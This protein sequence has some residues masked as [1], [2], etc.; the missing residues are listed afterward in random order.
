MND[1]YIR[2]DVERVRAKVNDLLLNF[3]ELAADPDLLVDTLEG[4]SDYHKVLE[5]LLACIL[6]LESLQTAIVD[7]VKSLQKRGEH[8]GTAADKLRDMARELL[9]ESGLKSV[10]LPEATLSLRQT[11]P[12]VQVL[13][14]TLIPDYY[15]RVKR[16]VNKILIRS[17]L[18]S[19]D[20]I[21]GA[22][23]GNPSIVLAIKV[24]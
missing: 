5:R 21:P 3:P 17:H 4:E 19:G 10:K 16:E 12:K 14:E 11:P 23:L 7:R 20:E 2:F 24:T 1:R 15:W 9:E 13:D 22:T 6:G 8:M 18:Q